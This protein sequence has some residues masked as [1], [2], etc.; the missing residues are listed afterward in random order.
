MKPPA[1]QLDQRITIQQSTPTKNDRGEAIPAWSTLATVWA[2]AE[3]LRGREFFA[4][5][6]MQESVDVKFTIRYRD[7][8][9]AQMRVLWRGQPH[10]IVSPPIDVR[11]QRESLELMCVQGIRDGR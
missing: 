10:D 8:I 9:T 5:A 6:Q 7:D 11:G 4:A 3:P 1:G 2:K